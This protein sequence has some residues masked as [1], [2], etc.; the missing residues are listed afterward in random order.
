MPEGEED[1]PGRGLL[2]KSVPY[3][4]GDRVLCDQG[5]ISDCWRDAEAKGGEQQ[6]E[7]D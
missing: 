4:R 5:A 2:Q 3:E 6:S 1:R 7:A